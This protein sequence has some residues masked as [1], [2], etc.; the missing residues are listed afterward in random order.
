MQGFNTQPVSKSRPGWLIFALMIQI[1]D[2]HFGYADQ[3]ILSIP[4]MEVD[5]AGHLLILG[6]SGSGKTTL[7]HI[8]GGL[9]SPKQ[10]K[11]KIGETDL[12]GLS[13]AQRD[14]YRGQNIGLIFQKAH[15]ISAL[16]VME[17]LLLAQYLS[18]T[19]QDKGRALEVLNELNLGDKQNKKVRRLSQGEQQRV[20]IARA[21]L[22]APRLILADE[23]TASLD[24]ANAQV[25]IDMLKAQANKYRAALIIAT[26]DQRVK[27]SFELQLN[28]TH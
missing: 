5:E 24:D 9:L 3:Q 2:L 11:V 8:L 10:G 22:N 21:L 4:H 20:T 15:L 16:T 6:S 23:P 12:Y 18:G 1:D 25:V 17:N 7:L 26:H 27:D 14:R 28:L 13:G 19:A